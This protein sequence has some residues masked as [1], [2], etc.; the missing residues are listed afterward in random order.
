MQPFSLDHL[1]ETQFEEFCFDLLSEMGLI[2]LKWR[3]GTG[4]PTSPSDRGRD[5]EF[6]RECVDVDK[7]KYFETWFVE[8]KHSKKGVSPDKLLGAI[9][10]ATAERP[11][12]LLIITSN[13][14]SNP[15]HDY[16]EIFQRKSMPH[17]RIRIWEKPDLEKHVEGKS[18]LLRKYDVKYEIVDEFPF[19][20][21]YLGMERLASQLN[22]WDVQQALAN[23]IASLR[24]CANHQEYALRFFKVHHSYPIQLVYGSPDGAHSLK[25]ADL[26]AA[27]EEY[28]QKS[29]RPLDEIWREIDEQLGHFLETRDLI[30]VDEV[31][32]KSFAE[33]SLETMSNLRGKYPLF[34]GF[35]PLHEE[36]LI[37]VLEQEGLELYF[38][39]SSPLLSLFT[40]CIDHAG[41]VHRAVIIRGGLHPA[42][43]EYLLG[44]EL[45]HWFLHMKRGFTE[46]YMGKNFYLQSPSE[47]LNFEID[48]DSFAMNALLP[49]AYLAEHEIFHGELSAKDIL[50]EFTK[51]MKPI[52]QDLKQ[53]ILRSI[54][55]R[56]QSYASFKDSVLPIRIPV[57]TIE[58]ESV[59]PFLDL[60]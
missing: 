1:D 20:S 28:Q 11:D 47:W 48:A 13:F 36:Q 6:Q 42:L 50:S 37:S 23:A 14:L 22:R 58:E 60:L 57:D 45:G 52:S 27:I 3:K 9:T 55:R 29:K 41:K 2:N 44:H 26:G 16:L 19:L 38:M 33:E 54:E 18:R 35:E 46:Q 4:L 53:N 56:I 25:E 31:A 34:G 10:W 12:V 5:I 40:E 43:R 7:R 59:K 32:I 51:A 8:C 39:D 17:F 24:I 15:A 21:N 49:A 30:G